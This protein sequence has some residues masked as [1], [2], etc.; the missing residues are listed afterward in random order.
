MIHSNSFTSCFSSEIFT[1][2]SFLIAIMAVIAIL[3]LFKISYRNSHCGSVGQEL[4]IVSLRMCIWSLTSLSGLKVQLLLKVCGVD[5]RN[6][7]DL[8]LLW[9][10]CRPE[11]VALIQPPD[12]ELHYAAGVAIKKKKKKKKKRSSCCGPVIWLI[13]MRMQVWSVPC[14]VG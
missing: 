2:I 3:S 10:W 8:L 11:A 13:S 9:L 14:A 4:D 1:F 5:C 12:W 6:T 7:S